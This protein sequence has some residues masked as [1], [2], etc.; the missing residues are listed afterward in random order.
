MYSSAPSV[1]A[2]SANADGAAAA[3]TQ[4]ITAKE[5]EIRLAK[6]R[7]LQIAKA[8]TVAYE[9]GGATA[10][11]K[12]KAASAALAALALDAAEEQTATDAIAAMK[13][14]GDDAGQEA[15]VALVAEKY[16]PDVAAAAL[17]EAILLDVD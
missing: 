14:L 12:A 6:E 11:D 4:A 7:R 13:D 10:N 15:V 1:L 3:I 2:D 17:T 9:T 8:I 16:A 5:D